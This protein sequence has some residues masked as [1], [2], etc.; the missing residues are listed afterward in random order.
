VVKYP[1]I[2]VAGDSLDAL[3]PVPSLATEVHDR[4]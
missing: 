4:S 3:C 2:A 1:L